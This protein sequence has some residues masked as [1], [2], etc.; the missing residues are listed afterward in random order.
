MLFNVI[1]LK[2]K[3]ILE[4]QTARH[5]TN[6]VLLN[7]IWPPNLRTF[8]LCQSAFDLLC[9]YFSITGVNIDE[10]ILKTKGICFIYFVDYIALAWFVNLMTLPNISP[11]LGDFGFGVVRTFFMATFR[12]FVR[13][14]FIA[15]SPK[16]W[17]AGTW[18]RFW[19]LFSWFFMTTLGKNLWSS[20]KA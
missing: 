15:G 17:Y 18:S 13:S 19:V 2:G 3:N 6:I 12:T 9:T 5:S 14:S 4:P 16:A 1:S 8:D 7:H 11:C 10:N 20:C